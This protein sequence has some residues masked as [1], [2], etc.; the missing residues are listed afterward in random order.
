M[1]KIEIKLDHDENH[2]IYYQGIG[3]FRTDEKFR[4]FYDESNNCRK[5]WIKPK[6]EKGKFNTSIYEDFVLAGVVYD[7]DDF[8]VNFDHMI[9]L[10]GLQ[11]NVKEIKFKSHFS[12]KSFLDCVK[13]K[14]L[15]TLLQWID[16]NNLFLHYSHVN[17]LY[18]ALVEIID[19]IA[20]PEEIADY[21]FDYFSI[22]S[23]LYK[24]L[25]KKENDLQKLMF[26]YCFPN[27]K[28][29]DIKG[30]CN[31]LL[32]LFKDRY[33][34]N[35]EE[36]F[37]TGMIGRA[38]VSDSLI[39]IQDNEDYVMQENYVEFYINPIRTY[40]NSIHIFDEELEI[41]RELDKYCFT[42]GGEVLNSFKFVNSKDEVLVQ[43]SDVIAGII[44]KMFSYI[45]CKEL[46][47][48]RRDVSELNQVQVAN[49]QLINELRNKAD[50]RNKGFLHSLA[51]QHEINLLNMFFDLVNA[52]K[53]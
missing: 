32:Q 23:T 27:I 28:K 37:I 19:S 14:R 12:E 10:L 17:N 52:K 50:K 46:K 39:F 44:G 24:M 5:F 36:K 7:G 22:K 53:I 41:Q 43:I 51:P 40:E 38:S 48:I 29:N 30:F 3:G 42:K 2:Q 1:D 8:Q 21:G 11:K 4:F 20:N 35:V 25:K 15:T 47:D 26:D 34:Q 49:I 18:Y 33:D 9:N 6:E 31:G 16:E 45:N 13:K